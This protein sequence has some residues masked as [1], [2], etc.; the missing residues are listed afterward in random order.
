MTTFFILFSFVA[1]YSTA[2]TPDAAYIIGG[3][4]TRNFES[5]NLVAEFRNDKWAQLDHLNK[6]RHAHASITVGTQ[7]MI[8]GGS[9]YGER[10]V[11]ILP[12]YFGYEDSDLFLSF[13]T[14]VWELDVGDNKVITPTLTNYYHGIGL[15]AVNFNFCST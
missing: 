2:N 3:W 12:H 15:Y 1:Y 11:M 9:A 8:V 10:L 7:I 13:E 4:N 5:R 14:E 6:E